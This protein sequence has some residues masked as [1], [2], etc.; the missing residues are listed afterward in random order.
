LIHDQP[1]EFNECFG[2]LVRQ[3]LSGRRDFYTTK[4]RWE[5]WISD[6]ALGKM[7]SRSPLLFFSLLTE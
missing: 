1:E 4:P 2:L 3:V 6:S 7:A 5:G